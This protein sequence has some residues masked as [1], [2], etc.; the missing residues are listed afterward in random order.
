MTDRTVE[1]EAAVRAQ[2]AMIDAVQRL[3]TRYLVK[4]IESP[5]LVDNLLTLFDGPEQR[6]TQRV[7]RGAGKSRLVAARVERLIS[8]RAPSGRSGRPLALIL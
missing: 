6:E 5:T 2:D 8:R 3:L 1:L 4:E 7:V